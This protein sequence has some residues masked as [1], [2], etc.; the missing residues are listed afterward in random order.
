MPIVSSQERNFHVSPVGNLRFSRSYIFPRLYTPDSAVGIFSHPDPFVRFSLIH[1][2]VAGRPIHRASTGI[3]EASGR[4]VDHFPIHAATITPI[5]PIDFVYRK[6]EIS[7]TNR[8]VIS[9]V[10]PAKTDWNTINR[11]FKVIHFAL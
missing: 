9:T 10:R 1:N 11:F 3:G 7:A 8:N 2:D 4:L 6:L 5:G